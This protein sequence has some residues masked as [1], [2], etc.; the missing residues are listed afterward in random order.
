M[1]YLLNEYNTFRRLLI[2]SLYYCVKHKIKKMLQL[3]NYSFLVPTT[4]YFLTA[5][6]S[7]VCTI[8]ELT[9][10]RNCCTNWHR[11]QQSAVDR[12]RVF[13]PAW[14]HCHDCGYDC[15][16]LTVVRRRF[17]RSKSGVQGPEFN[18]FL[19]TSTT[20]PRMPTNSVRFGSRFLTDILRY[21]TTT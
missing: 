9:K 20:T 5:L 7:C 12:D 17:T 3:L 8:H 21:T 14:S 1:N 18:F 13:S 4:I 2:T 6:S 10:L 19:R 11:L 15:P 16:R